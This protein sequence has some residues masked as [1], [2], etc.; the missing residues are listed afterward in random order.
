MTIDF[1]ETLRR[2]ARKT[3]LVESEHGLRDAA[4]RFARDLNAELRRAAGILEAEPKPDPVPAPVPVRDM[5]AV[6]RA[7][8]Y[9]PEPVIYPQPRSST[10]SADGGPR[11]SVPAAPSMNEAIRD[12]ASAERVAAMSEAAD[13]HE[14]FGWPV[15]RKRRKR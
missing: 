6:L 15:G 5:N 13:L 9:D 11:A 4:G 2:V 10:G 8:L 3:D 14:L 12:A 1:S 7:A